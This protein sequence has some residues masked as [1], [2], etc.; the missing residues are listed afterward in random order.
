VRG[1]QEDR[2]RHPTR[3]GIGRVIALAGQQSEVFAPPD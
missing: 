3:C 1:T 2:D